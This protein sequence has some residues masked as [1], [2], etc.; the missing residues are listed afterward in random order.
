MTMT[1]F[2]P[3]EDVALARRIEAGVLAQAALDDPHSCPDATAE[4]LDAL[5]RDGRAAH[6]ALVSRHLGL[7]RV[8]ANDAARRHPTSSQDYFQEGCLALQRAVLS[9]DWRRGRFSA[10]AGAWIRAAMRRPQETAHFDLEPDRVV[11]ERP[12]SLVERRLTHE[13]LA[14]VLNA[15]PRQERSVVA[16][17]HG[18]EGEPLTLAQAA[19]QLSTTIAKVRRLER[20]GLAHARR[21]C[22]ETGAF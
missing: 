21:F 20:D 3:A 17:R 4:E 19:E 6:E 10:Y 1:F 12:V 2:D 5:A 11:D 15:L 14:A 16:L 13:T 9:F 8:I 7:V 22:Q 18:W